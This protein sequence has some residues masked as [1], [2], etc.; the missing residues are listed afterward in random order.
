MGLIADRCRGGEATSF[1]RRAIGGEMKSASAASQCVP[2]RAEARRSR[3]GRLRA[4][5]VC[6]L[7]RLALAALGGLAATCAAPPRVL[8]EQPVE[9]GIVLLFESIPTALDPEAVRAA[10]ERELG[11]PVT[12]ADAAPAGRAA[13]RLRA[14][15]DRRVTL[16]YHAEDGRR[17]ARTI[18]LPEDGAGDVEIIA[19]LAGNLMR[20]EA[21]ELAAALGKRAAAE[22]AP[23]AEPEPAPLAEPDPAPLAEPDVAAPPQ[24]CE[25]AGARAVG[26]GTDVF[27][28]LG[29][30][31]F[32]GVD[33][34][35][36]YSLGLFGTY[37]A[38]LDGIEA[39]AGVNIK[40]S[41]MCGLQLSSMANLVH[42]PARGAQLGAV[43]YARGPVMGLQ[44]GL[45]NIARGEVDG[46]QI[47][48]VNYAHRSTLSFGLINIIRDGRLHLDLW[49]LESRVVL[50]GLEH[51]GDHF[52]SIYGLGGRVSQRGGR[53]A[54]AFGVGGRVPISRRLYVDLD[55]LGY[56]LHDA[57]SRH[58][59]SILAQTRLLLVARLDPRF[60]IFGGPSY[61]LVFGET[62]EET[63]LS[64]YG[65][66]SLDPDDP[67]RLRGWPG[68]V[69]G[70]RAF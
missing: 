35:R 39:S 48:L 22:P 68:L 15:P 32:T 62:A 45:V 11:E 41:F 56:A 38:G 67:D 4:R 58:E 44:I 25:R 26:L 1:A 28:F 57:S 50:A 70:V 17:L 30:S 46:A 29:S 24:P 27:P 51:G 8:A 3:P 18:A 53:L 49:A 60:A 6:V 55:L 59:P 13:L 37:T 43:N 47:G 10:I 7:A 42:G 5:S 36:R 21:S 31:T 40:S 61:N 2:S 33:V 12:L 20:D 63:E 69:V 14:E 66:M 52:H 16:V 54:A 23:L 19:L 34:V 64:P 65:S 9:S